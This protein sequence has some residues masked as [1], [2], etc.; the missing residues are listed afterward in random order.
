MRFLVLSSLLLL[1]LLYITSIHRTAVIHVITLATPIL[2]DPIMF[3][4]LYERGT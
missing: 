3:G 1:L 2:T 4:E